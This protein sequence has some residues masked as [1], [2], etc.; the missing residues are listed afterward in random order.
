MA[1]CIK[2]VAAAAVFVF[3]YKVRHAHSFWFLLLLSEFIGDEEVD[4]CNENARQRNGE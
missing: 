3:A 2:L 1:K 4:E